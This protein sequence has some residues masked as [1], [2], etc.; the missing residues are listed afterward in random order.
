MT[1]AQ[2]DQVGGEAAARAARRPAAGSDD[3]R[4]Q[5]ARA[6]A[7]IALADRVADHGE[8]VLKPLIEEWWRGEIVKKLRAGVGA[9]PRDQSICAAWN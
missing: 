4:Q 3:V 7:A 8:S 5:S 6:L 2:D 1:E 9:I